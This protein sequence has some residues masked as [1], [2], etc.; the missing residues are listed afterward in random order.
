M[1]IVDAIIAYK[2]VNIISTPWKQMDAYKKGIIDDKGTILIPRSKLKGDQVGAYPSVFYTLCWNIKRILTKL[3]LG[4]SIG[5]FIS[6]LYLLRE[7]IKEIKESN[8]A[9]ERIQVEALQILEEHGLSDQV[10]ILKESKETVMYPGIYRVG[11]ETFVVESP[12]LPHGTCMG[13]PVFKVGKRITNLIE[14]KKVEEDGAVSAPANNVGGG[15]IAGVSPGQEPP[16]PKGGYKALMKKRKKQMEKD[17]ETI[18]IVGPL[19]RRGE[20]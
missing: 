19:N 2:F 10:K 7:K 14:A 4:S 17:S 20:S 11:Y 6:A 1:S 12:V 3:G 16:G 15:A 18:N 13:I 9:W 8:S 5:S